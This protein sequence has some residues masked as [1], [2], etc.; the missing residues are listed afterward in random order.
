MKI[1]CFLEFDQRTSTV[2]M[3]HGKTGT[4]LMQIK[5]E[6]G[7]VGTMSRVPTDGSE[8]ADNFWLGVKPDDAT[9]FEEILF[10]DCKLAVNSIDYKLSGGIQRKRRGLD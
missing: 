4:R 5:L 8:D 2:T 3:T 9:V 1:P 6:A 7:A 10:G